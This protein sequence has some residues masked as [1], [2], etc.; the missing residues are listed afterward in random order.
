[1]VSR[2]YKIT[3]EDRDFGAITLLTKLEIGAAKN[4]QFLNRPSYFYSFFFHGVIRYVHG[5]ESPVIRPMISFKIRLDLYGRSV[6][7][8]PV[9]F[10]IQLG[11]WNINIYA[12][13]S[14]EM[15]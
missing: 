9:D 8:A 3:P 11:F 5:M 10:N 14:V 7:M 12:L 6:V 15:L 4:S 1:M 2:K 13:V